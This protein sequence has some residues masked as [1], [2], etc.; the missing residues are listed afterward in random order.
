MVKD[1]SGMR[2]YRSRNE[3]GELRQ[4][5]GDTHIDVISTFVAI[6]TWVRFLNGKV[7]YLSTIWSTVVTDED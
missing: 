5:R 4:K 3:D 2:G 1:A 7:Q 6:Y